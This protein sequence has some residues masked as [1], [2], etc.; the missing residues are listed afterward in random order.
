MLKNQRGVTAIGWLCLL[1][2]IAVCGYA[3]IRLAPIY[4]NYGKVVRTMDKLKT[5]A[6]ADD[7]R[8]LAVLKDGLGKRLDI[9]QIEF[10]TEKDFNIRRDGQAWV[11]DLAYEDTVPLFGNVSLLTTFTKSV[12]IGPPASTD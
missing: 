12:R 11:V 5:E 9:E 1:I 6:G 4:I 7:T 8:G 2:P 10:P 3:G